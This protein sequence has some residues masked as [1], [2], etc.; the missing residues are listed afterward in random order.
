MSWDDKGFLL[1]KLKYNENSIIADF[2]T[3]E[4]GRTSGIIFGASSKKIKG[5]L[6]IANELQ[7]NYQNK[8]QNKIGSFKVEIIKAETPFFFH[9]KKKLLCIAS[10]MS[11]IRLLT[12]EGQKNYDIYNLIKNF[13]E[14][15]KQENWLKNYVLWEL[16]LLKLVGYDLNLNKIV[17]SSVIN[18]EI[19]YFVENKAEKKIVPNFLVENNSKITDQKELIKGIKLVSNYLDKNILNP[20]NLNHPIQRTDFINIL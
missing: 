17:K 12:A 4:H 9:Q 14:F 6:Q 15:I 3:Y 20:N 5:Y 7:L 8:S 19:V 18:N 2:F 1:S 10:S 13:F 11:M 16:E